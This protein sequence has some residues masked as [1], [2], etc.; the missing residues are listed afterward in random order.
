MLWFVTVMRSRIPRPTWRS[1]MIAS[2]SC[3][4]R[5]PAARPPSNGIRSH[6]THACAA[7]TEAQLPSGARPPTVSR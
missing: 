4:S 5:G 6:A 2:W 7:S 1:M 3:G